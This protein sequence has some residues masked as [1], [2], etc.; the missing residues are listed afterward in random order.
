MHPSPSSGVEGMKGLLLLSVLVGCGGEGELA[1]EGIPPDTAGAPAVS[2]TGIAL[3]RTIEADGRIGEQTTAFSPAD[4]IY[5]SIETAGMSSGVTLGAR[6]MLQD[7]E[8]ISESSQTIAPEGPA[9]TEFHISRPEGW[10]PG[11]YRVVVSINDV[12]VRAEP[13]AVVAGGG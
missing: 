5:V 7:G 12:D 4:T 3:G 2:V 13:F 9:V 8:L 10:T 11:D 1:R 6:W